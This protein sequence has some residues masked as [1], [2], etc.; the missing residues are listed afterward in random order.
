M[1]RSHETVFRVGYPLAAHALTAS[2]AALD[3]WGPLPWVAMANIRTALE[4]A[5][6][7]QWVLLTGSS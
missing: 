5:L 1:H 7:A 3:L 2:A 4:H 6:A